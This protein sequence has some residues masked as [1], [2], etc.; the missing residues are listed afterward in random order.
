MQII[1]TAM[2]SVTSCQTIIRFFDNGRDPQSDNVR[3]C[4]VQSMIEA[5][6]CI[7]AAWLTVEEGTPVAVRIY[8]NE[9][10]AFDRIATEEAQ[11]YFG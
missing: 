6:G 10:S 2:F 3:C 5:D 11:S 1:H 8:G 4:D 7:Y 9:D